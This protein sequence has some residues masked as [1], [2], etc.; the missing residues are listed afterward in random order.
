MAADEPIAIIGAACRFP[1]GADSLAE[2]WQRLTDRR[3]LASE[4][5]ADRWDC[6]RSMSQAWV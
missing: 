3:V 1:G 4:V 2:F 6:H 5:P